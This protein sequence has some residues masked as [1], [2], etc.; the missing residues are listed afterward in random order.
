MYIV[1][2]NYATER[3]MTWALSSTG[4]LVPVLSNQFVGMLGGRSLHTSGS[5]IEF[6]NAL[7][8]QYMC[9]GSI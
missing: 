1:Y 9:R 7:D 3:I 8:L 4:V 6:T 5:K 2:I